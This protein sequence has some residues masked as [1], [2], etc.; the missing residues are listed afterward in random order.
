MLRYLYHFGKLVGFVQ[1]DVSMLDDVEVDAASDTQMTETSSWLAKEEGMQLN[2]LI[3]GR[4]R[5]LW[6]RFGTRVRREEIDE[7]DSPRRR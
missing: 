4:R 6:P 2:G 1:M 7:V 5:K 3:E